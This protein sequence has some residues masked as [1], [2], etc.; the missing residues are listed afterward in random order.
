MVEPDG[1]VTGSMTLPPLVSNVTVCMTACVPQRSANTPLFSRPM[2]TSLCCSG[3]C[4]KLFD[5][6]MMG[7]AHHT[8]ELNRLMHDAT[9]TTLESA[10]SGTVCGA[11][12]QIGR[13]HVT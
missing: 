4:S 9:I 8:E 10:V 11:A 6:N 3:T 7:S 2:K 1:A 5:V 13:D 12:M